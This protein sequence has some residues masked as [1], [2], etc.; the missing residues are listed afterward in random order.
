MSIFY[1]VSEAG[2]TSLKRALSETPKTGSLA[3]GPNF[4]LHHPL[5]YHAIGNLFGNK[6]EVLKRLCSATNE[7]RHVIS[8]NAASDKCRLRRVSA[9]SF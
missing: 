8:I 2:E 1:Q 9:A 3:K 7:P 4:I 6:D 5:H